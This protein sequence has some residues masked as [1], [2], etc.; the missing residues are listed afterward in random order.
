M[1]F[2]I[3]WHVLVLS[4]LDIFCDALVMM[5][6]MALCFNDYVSILVIFLSYDVNF[7]H[8]YGHI[9]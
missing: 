3:E 4:Y 5:F 9:S 6:F 8:N 7:E 1:F 2:F